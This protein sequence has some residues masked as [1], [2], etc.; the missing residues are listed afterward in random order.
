M[1]SVFF[2]NIL[3]KGTGTTC[4]A[5]LQF[6]PPELAFYISGSKSDRREKNLEL[7]TE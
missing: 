3:H 4:K 6:P 7:E 5:R 1:E 2:K